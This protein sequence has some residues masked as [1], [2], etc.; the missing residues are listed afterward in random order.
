MT[1]ITLEVDSTVGSDIARP[2]LADVANGFKHGFPVG[3]AVLWDMLGDDGRQMQALVLM[4]EPALPGAKVAARPVALL[5]IVHIDQCVDELLCVSD[6][7]PFSGVVDLDDFVQ[8]HA[9]PVAWTALVQRLQP[10]PQPDLVGCEPRGIAEL[11]L[12]DA[13]H[14]F[15]GASG[16]IDWLED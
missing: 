12:A 7:P 15:L 16:R 10:G 9:D 2:T 8:W 13:K 1:R 14:N 4:A 6:G 3:H 5:H 11:T